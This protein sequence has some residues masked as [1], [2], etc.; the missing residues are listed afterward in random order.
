M[1]AEPAEPEERVEEG[2]AMYVPMD[3]D[4]DSIR[5]TAS[6]GSAFKGYVRLTQLDGEAIGSTSR[7]R[8][9]IV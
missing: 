4:S 7:K 3:S 1:L 2:G 9:Q 8:I 5:S 6:R